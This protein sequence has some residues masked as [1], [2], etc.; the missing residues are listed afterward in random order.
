QRLLLVDFEVVRLFRTQP[1]NAPHRAGQLTARAFHALL[2][3][4]LYSNRRIEARAECLSERVEGHNGVGVETEQAKERAHLGP[5]ADD[6]EG[7]AVDHHRLSE[8]VLAGKQRLS[9]VVTENADVL[10]ATRFHVGEES[11]L[12]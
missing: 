4:D 7:I 5:D 1:A 10:T 9:H 3:L 12:T 8:R 11:P 2:I 6:A